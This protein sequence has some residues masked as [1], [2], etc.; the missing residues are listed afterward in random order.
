[1]HHYGE[2]REQKSNLVTAVAKGKLPA[3]RFCWCYGRFFF[4]L[5]KTT[6][7]LIMIVCCF[8]FFNN[9]DDLRCPVS[10]QKFPKGDRCGVVVLSRAGPKPCQYFFSLLILFFF[11]LEKKKKKKRKKKN[12]LRE[13]G[14]C[15]SISP[16]IMRFCSK[17]CSLFSQFSGTN[18][19]KYHRLGSLPK[20]VFSHDSGG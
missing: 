6:E 10:H 13:G 12:F 20:G 9:W 5:D 3:V 17:M 4:R 19:T 11:F 14:F 1:M 7:T 15:W 18:I 8:F 16:L 2:G